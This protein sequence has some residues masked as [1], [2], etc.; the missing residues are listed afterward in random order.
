MTV[1]ST[2]RWNWSSKLPMMVVLFAVSCGSLW[3][4]QVVPAPVP[5]AASDT[6]AGGSSSSTTTG[7]GAIGISPRSMLTADQID[8]VLQQR[9]EVIVA[10]KSLVAEQLPQKG[11]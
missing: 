2:G 3:A 1:L 4:Q 6:G 7:V 8:R 5:A 9:P 10:L 11:I